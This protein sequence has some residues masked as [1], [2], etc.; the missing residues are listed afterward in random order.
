MTQQSE[1]GG[2]VQHLVIG[3]DPDYRDYETWALNVRNSRNG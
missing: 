3:L 2:Q 1:C